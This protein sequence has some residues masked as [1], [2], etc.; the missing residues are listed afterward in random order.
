MFQNRPPDWAALLLSF[1]ARRSEF[2]ESLD[3]NVALFTLHYPLRPS[4]RTRRGTANIPS[5]KLAV[6]SPS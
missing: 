6:I 1:R 4:N 2:T 3:S 5:P